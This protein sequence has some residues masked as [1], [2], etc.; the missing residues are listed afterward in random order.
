[1]AK[2][3]D[4]VFENVRLIFK[5]F[6]GKED[7]FNAKGNR[8]FCLMIDPESAESMKAQ[9][10]NVKFLKPRTPEDPPA[11]YIKVNVSYK[12]SA[13]NVYLIAGNNGKKTAL[14]EETIMCLDSAEILNVDCVI[15]ASEWEPGHYS[16]YLKTMYVTIQP[17]PFA[18]KY[19]DPNE[20]GDLPWM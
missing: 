7:R 8:N 13:P 19:A 15:S 1:M 2:I 4:L 18:M 9:G 14:T 16:G 5:N 10:W 12:I 6:S 3:P 20:E 11:P 17:D